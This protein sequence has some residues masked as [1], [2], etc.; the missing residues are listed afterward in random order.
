HLGG[1]RAAQN[2]SSNQPGERGDGRSAEA[3]RLLAARADAV[4][5]DPYLMNN[6]DALQQQRIRS[7]RVRASPQD[8]RR[9]PH[10]NTDP[11]LATG[12]GILL[13]RAEPSVMR[14]QV[15]ASVAPGPMV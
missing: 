15:G 7:A 10:P 5:L 8:D 9:T 2:V 6:L 4:T 3:G 13:F 1:S 12:N 11:W 14:P